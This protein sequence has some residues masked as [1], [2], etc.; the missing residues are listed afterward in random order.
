MRSGRSSWLYE[1]VGIGTVRDGQ[2]SY[3]ESTTR[4]DRWV[5]FADTWIHV[6]RGRVLGRRQPVVP[7][8]VPTVT[9][10]HL[11]IPPSG[12]F[13]RP[14]LHGDSRKATRP[15]RAGRDSGVEMRSCDGRA[16]VTE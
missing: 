3:R 13:R 2:T 4:S 1:D 9:Q 16:I 5:L 12:S 6:A 7:A 11:A 8:A 14:S 10:A 15:V